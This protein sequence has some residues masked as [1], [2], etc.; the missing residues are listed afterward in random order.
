M[1]TDPILNLLRKFNQNHIVNHLRSLNPWQ[2]QIL[3]EN[4]QKVDL[5][6]AFDIHRT[7]SGAQGSNKIIGNLESASIIPIPKT[8]EEQKSREEA[9]G[10]G[11]ALIR[12]K[13]LAVLIVAGGQGSRLGFVGPKGKYPISPLMKKSLFQLFAESVKAL[14]VRFETEIPLLIMT[15]HEN[16]GE[17]REFF[18]ENQYFGLSSDGVEFFSQGMLPTLTPAGELILS[19]ETHLLMNPDGHG[20]SLKAFHESGLLKKLIGKGYSELFYC[21]V[22]NPIVKIADPVFLGYHNS[23][24]AEFSTKVVRR[25]S[26]EEKV[27]IYGL[28]NGKPGIIE[29]SD[30]SQEDYQG[31]DENGNIRHWAGNIAVHCISLTFI[32]RLNSHGFALPYHR[33]IKE[34]EGLGRDGKTEKIKGWKFETFVFDAIP[35]AERT[36]CM[37]VVRDEE[38]SPVK[39]FEG[40]DSPETARKAMVELHRR[41]LMQAGFELAPGAKIEISPLLALDKDELINKTRG[42]TRK[43]A[44]DVY[45]DPTSFA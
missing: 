45:L 31:V 23:V 44:K 43:I 40:I 27:G 19:D 32:E 39:N 9:R 10:L 3:L 38:F 26:L 20:G 17:T 35:L 42:I 14:S 37:E 1:E 28:Q 34:V 29:Y 5:P 4:I 2:R 30:F 16:D 22:D 41:W 36:S 18:K 21:Q 7:H 11:E 24:N 13:K 15:S 12:G 25:K 6:L 33:A 8:R